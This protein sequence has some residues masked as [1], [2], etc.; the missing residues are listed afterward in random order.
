VAVS[1]PNYITTLRTMA[2]RQD[3]VYALTYAAYLE[4]QSRTVHNQYE[5]VHDT[6]PLSEL[7]PKFLFLHAL[8]YVQENNVPAFKE[9]L[10]QLTALYPESDVSPLAGRM[11][12]G[13]LEGRMVQG[14]S[15]ARGLIWS[16]A[17][18][19]AGDSTATD[20]E[21]QFV[22]DPT[23]PHLLILAYATD[24]INQNDLLFEVAKFN[25]ENYLVKDFDLEIIP[26]GDVSLLVIRG[27]DN[28]DE[29]DDYH[30]KMELPAAGLSLPDGMEAID[31][32][33]QN[34]RVLLSGK[35]FQEYFE[36]MGMEDV[37]ADEVDTEEGI[38][39]TE[40]SSGETN[41]EGTNSDNTDS[42]ETEE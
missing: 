8:S 3:S 1:D 38:N 27:F 36:F 41:S 24:S 37:P 23:L 30:D 4:G 32:S 42:E 9:A 7:M 33:E 13:V 11:V 28:L 17:L 29:L 16:T 12:K 20:E 35:T 26:V 5:Y 31:I 15:T 10:E 22:D 6:W 18:R 21:T 2:A 39:D 19:A 14:G 40:D 25:F 34:F